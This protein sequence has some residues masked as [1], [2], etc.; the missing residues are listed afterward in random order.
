MKRGC[1]APPG[2]TNALKHG[3]YSAN[4]KP[5]EKKSLDEIPG[6]D[7]EAEI[8]TLRVFLQRFLDSESENPSQDFDTRRSSLLTACFAASRIAS[9]VRAQSRGKG[10]LLERSQVK[11]WL[12]CLPSGDLD[13]EDAPPTP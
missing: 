9:L 8:Y 10:Y 4:F 5:F 7:L 2:N 6:T 13:E 11:A 3:Y 12:D 1:G